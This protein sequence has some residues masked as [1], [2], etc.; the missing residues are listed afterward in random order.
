MGASSRSLTGSEIQQKVLHTDHIAPYSK[1]RPL[2]SYVYIIS[3]M[4]PKHQYLS[5]T[6][7]EVGR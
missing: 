1:I 3:F 6:S 4:M 2:K 5:E 7:E